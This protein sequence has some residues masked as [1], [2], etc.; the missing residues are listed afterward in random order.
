MYEL[1]RLKFGFMKPD[2]DGQLGHAQLEYRADCADGKGMVSTSD[3][4]LDGENPFCIEPIVEEGE[5][6][7]V[8]P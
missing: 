6:D 2:P 3:S 7:I 4:R 5:V 1:G 8:E